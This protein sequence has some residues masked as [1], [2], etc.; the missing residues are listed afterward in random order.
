MRVFIA[1]VSILS[2]SF[3]L[4]SAVYITISGA[5]IKRAKFALGQVH[6]LPDSTEGNPALAKKIRDELRSDLEFSQ[7]FDF[8]PDEG[9][10]DSDKPKDLYNIRYDALGGTGASFLLKLGYRLQ[11]GRLFLEAILYDIAGKKKIFGTRYQYQANQY[12]RLV[13][14]LAED[15]LQELTGERGLYLS[16]VVMVCWSKTQA[17]RWLYVLGILRLARMAI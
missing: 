10:S 7:L 1:I 4:H 8:I 12:F 2:F 15:I 3:P 11:G 5:N 14:T 16:R 6:P 17:T 13:H 9:F